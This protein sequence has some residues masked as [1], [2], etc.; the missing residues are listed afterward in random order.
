M[1][2]RI[3]FTNEW[4]KQYDRDFTAVIEETRVVIVFDDRRYDTISFDLKREI[5]ESELE[6]VTRFILDNYFAKHT[7]KFYK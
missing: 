2:G 3:E 7:V 5:D 1:R 6:T 4:L